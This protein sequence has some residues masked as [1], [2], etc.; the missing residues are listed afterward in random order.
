MSCNKCRQGKPLPDDT[1]CLGCSAWESLGTELCASWSQPALRQAAVDIVVNTVREVRTL[2]GISSSLRSAESSSRAAGQYTR[3]RSRSP[4]RAP[5]PAPRTLP[6]PPPPPARVKAQQESSESEEHERDS[7][8]EE[9]AAPATTA[10]PKSDPS[11][12]PPEPREPPRGST[13]EAEHHS[14]S[15]HHRTGEKKKKKS[16]K[17]RGGRNHQRLY[18]TLEDPEARVHRRLPGSFWD[19]RSDDQGRAALERRR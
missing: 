14:R 10:A 12:R 1:W 2:R 4:T 16:G 3:E 9:V 6:A 19:Q 7:E 17:H 11:R 5:K 8:D 15:D 18:R 13:G